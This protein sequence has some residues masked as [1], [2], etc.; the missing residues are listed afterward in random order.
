MS[1]ID[2][3]WK[4]RFGLADELERPGVHVVPHARYAGDDLVFVF[5]KG[6]ATVLSV[7]RSCVDSVRDRVRHVAATA[8]LDPVQVRLVIDGSVSHRVGPLYEGC[9]EA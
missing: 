6:K 9:A 2:R 5:V 8:L 3:Y 1:R 7:E 4:D